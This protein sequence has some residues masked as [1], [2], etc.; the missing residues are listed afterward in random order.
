MWHCTQG[1]DFDVC[2]ACISGAP[3]PALCVTCGVQRAAPGHQTC[4]RGCAVGNDCSCSVSRQPHQH[5]GV[6]VDRMTYEDMLAMFGDGSQVK[7][8]SL[9]DIHVLPTRVLTPGEVGK[10]PEDAQSCTVCMDDYS[11]AGGDEIRTLP[12]M[13]VFHKDCIDEWLARN[14]TCPICKH[15]VNTQDSDAA[16][17][18]SPPSHSTVPPLTSP[19][20]LVTTTTGSSDVCI[21]C[22][23]LPKTAP[24]ET[25][26]RGC[27]VGTQCSCD[28]PDL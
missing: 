3:P 10:L 12:C 15:S 22:G 16:G 17:A 9:S 1:C 26:C 13:H 8:A 28:D 18:D 20:L 6:D 14:S 27:A 21:A 25:C 2:D 4:C 23:V 11:E 24:H 5:H 7:A 19:S